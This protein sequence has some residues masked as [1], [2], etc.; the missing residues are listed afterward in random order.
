MKLPSIW[1]DIIILE[2][3]NYV[4]LVMGYTVF[5]STI[6]QNILQVSFQNPQDVKPSTLENTS[7]YVRPLN[8]KWG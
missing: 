6:T 8:T 5:L 1:E 2:D 3:K 7:I 4:C